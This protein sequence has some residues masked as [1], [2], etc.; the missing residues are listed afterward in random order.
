MS[1]KNIVIILENFIEKLENI[2]KKIV[3]NHLKNIKHL[4]RIFNYLKHTN[5]RVYKFSRILV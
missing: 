2:V 4:I 5:F 3:N 1:H